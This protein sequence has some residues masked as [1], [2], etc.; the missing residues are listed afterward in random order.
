MSIH[1]IGDNQ[2]YFLFYI[3]LQLGFLSPL[4]RPPDWV[5]YWSLSLSA[6]AM[7]RQLVSRRTY[8]GRGHWGRTTIYDLPTYEL[9][10]TDRLPGTTHDAFNPYEHM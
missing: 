4:S 9:R 10:P 3:I 6:L 8:P 5:S 1:Y 7:T 2:K